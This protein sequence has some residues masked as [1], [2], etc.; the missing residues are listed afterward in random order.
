MTS[1]RFETGRPRDV[2]EIVAVVHDGDLDDVPVDL[3]I[4]DPMRRSRVDVRR[5][6]TSPASAVAR[7]AQRTNTVRAAGTIVDDPGEVVGAQRC[8]PRRRRAR[9]RPRRAAPADRHRGP[10][11][12]LIVRLI[13]VNGRMSTPATSSP[14]RTAWRE[15]HRAGR[16]AVDADRP[17]PHGDN[18]AVDRDDLVIGRQAHG[19]GGDDGRVGEHA[20]GFAARHQPTVGQVRPVGERLGNGLEPGRVGGAQQLRA[21]QP[22]H[23]RRRVVLA[24]TPRRRPAPGPA[25]ATVAWYSAPCGFTYLTPAPATCANPSSAPSW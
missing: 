12:G 21:G 23:C 1:S 11:T 22:E 20:V 7:S 10:S 3:A 25:S 8:S 4:V 2:V 13:D 17:G 9:R 14:A 24:R 5:P 19:P 15:L 18:R 6:A 16:V